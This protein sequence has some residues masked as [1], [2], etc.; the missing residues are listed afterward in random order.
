MWFYNR[1]CVIYYNIRLRGDK[2][3]NLQYLSWLYVFDIHYGSHN[4]III[5][6]ENKFKKK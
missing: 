2:M 1:L 6:N 3:N 4:Y 5:M